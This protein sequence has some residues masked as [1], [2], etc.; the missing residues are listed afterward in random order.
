MEATVATVAK[1]HPIFSCGD[2]VTWESQSQGTTTRKTGRITAVVP[3]HT[4]VQSILEHSLYLRNARRYNRST[5]GY[6]PARS[7]ISYLVAVET[8]TRR[9][10]IRVRAKLY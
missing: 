4:S 2:L 6:S 9:G 1:T 10:K 5:L 8:T 7:H 3:A